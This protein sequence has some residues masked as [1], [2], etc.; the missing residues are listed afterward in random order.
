Q[1]VKAAYAR[2]K[3]D[4]KAKLEKTLGLSGAELAKLTGQGFLKTK[5]FQAKYDEVP[6]SKVNNVKV[7]GDQATVTYTE[8]DGDKEKLRLFLQKGEWKVSAPM[9]PVALP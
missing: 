9:P 5:R 3:A 1:V 7:D 8:E 4:R 6:G 2:A